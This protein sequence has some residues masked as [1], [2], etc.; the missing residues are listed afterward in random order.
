HLEREAGGYAVHTLV[1][2]GCVAIFL[3]G[4]RAR[5]GVLQALAVI[6]PHFGVKVGI[7]MRFHSRQ[8]AETRQDVERR[9]RAGGI[10]QFAILQ[11]LL[12][13][14]SLLGRTQAI[15]PFYYR[16]GVDE[17]LIFFV[18][19]KALPLGLF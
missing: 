8:H 2:A 5:I 14:F 11:K 1:D 12:V 16:N 3:H 18:F 7:L 6:H 9:R 13:V 17:R 19:F 15:W 4:F 10:G